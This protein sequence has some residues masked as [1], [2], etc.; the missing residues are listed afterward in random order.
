MSPVLP[1]VVFVLVAAGI[2]YLIFWLEK[3]RTAAWQG[4]A[5][6]LGADLVPKGSTI[7]NRFPF[8]LFNKGSRRKAKNHMKWESEGVT[9]HLVDYQYTVYSHTGRNRSSKTYKRT[10]CILEKEGLELPRTFL[11]REIKVLD[12][13]GSKF[14]AQD[15]GF[16]EDP[17]FSK[18]FVVKGDEV[19]T[20]QIL[21]HEL[22]QHLLQNKKNFRTVEMNGNAIMLNF[23]KRRKPEE[24]SDLVA[25]AMPVYYM[26]SSGGS[27]W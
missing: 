3:K 15:I 26:A 19:R 13:V 21:T 18:A 6:R 24:Y 7:H 8:D 5:Q 20:P 12:W 25:L 16:E 22:R 23:G 11:R 14:G 27:A 9:V 17:E 1:I 10:V 4:I 2:I